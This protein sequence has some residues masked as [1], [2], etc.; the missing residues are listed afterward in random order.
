VGCISHVKGLSQL[1]CVSGP[2]A[3]YRQP[4]RS[5][6]EA[7]LAAVVSSALKTRQKMRHL[8]EV[9]RLQLRLYPSG[10]ASWKKSP[11][12]LQAGR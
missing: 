11:G 3:F 5:A 9:W 6:F 7:C 12:E 8:T 10:V 4:L 2:E 1:L